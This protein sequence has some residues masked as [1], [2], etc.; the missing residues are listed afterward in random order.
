MI[1]LFNEHKIIEVK[2]LDY[3]DFCK[4]VEIINRKDHLTLEGLEK[5]KLIKS[6][7]NKGRIL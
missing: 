1:P 3:L 5:I 2:S 6:G 4:V 7:M